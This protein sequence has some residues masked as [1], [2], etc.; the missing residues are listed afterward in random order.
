MDTHYTPKDLP[1]FADIGEEGP[2]PAKEFFD[3][4]GAVSN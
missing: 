4:Y 1:K 3:Y 2:Q